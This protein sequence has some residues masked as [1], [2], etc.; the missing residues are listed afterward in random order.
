MK[1]ELKDELKCFQVL[2][3][4]RNDVDEGHHSSAGANIIHGRGLPAGR[5]GD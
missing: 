4:T 1:N 5:S 2:R 3:S